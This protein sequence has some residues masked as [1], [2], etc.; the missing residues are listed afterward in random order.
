MRTFNNVIALN[1]PSIMVNERLIRPA[2][3]L[4]AATRTIHLSREAWASLAVLTPDEHEQIDGT[5][6]QARAVFIDEE[7]TRGLER[8]LELVD[9]AHMGRS[10]DLMVWLRRWRAV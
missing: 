7:D 6:M 10:V 8:F 3:W 5:W 9:A 1:E 2:P 4:S